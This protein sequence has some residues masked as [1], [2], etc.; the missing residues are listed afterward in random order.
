MRGFFIS[1]S[2]ICLL[3]ICVHALAY[4]YV[5]NLSSSFKSSAEVLLDNTLKLF[6]EVSSVFGLDG[7]GTHLGGTKVSH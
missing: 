7:L 1:P 2:S 6:K 3:S 4:T 5:A